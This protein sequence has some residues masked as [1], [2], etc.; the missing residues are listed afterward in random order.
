M[1]STG[2]VCWT[3]VDSIANERI[4]HL[5]KRCTVYT[6]HLSEN[7]HTHTL[8]EFNQNE[9]NDETYFD[10]L[11]LENRFSMSVSRIN[12][13][14]ISLK[15]ASNRT[16]FHFIQQATKRREKKYSKKNNNYCIRRDKTNQRKKKLKKKC[17]SLVRLS[18]FSIPVSRLYNTD[19]HF[20][21]SSYKRKKKLL[22]LNKIFID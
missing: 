4:K 17:F 13:N 5:F 15:S 11:Q 21:E 19:Q 14:C 2:I 18:L 16:A 8:F 6:K 7:T 22:N 9:Q 10:K 20:E 1:K 3:C 12:A